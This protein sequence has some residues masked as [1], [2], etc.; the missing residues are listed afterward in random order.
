MISINSTIEEK[1]KTIA[2]RNKNF[3]KHNEN[4]KTFNQLEKELTVFNFLFSQLKN[5]IKDI[6]DIEKGY[7]NKGEII[8]NYISLLES[9]S[10]SINGNIENI[11][12]N[13]MD[14]QEDGY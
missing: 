9:L 11:Y 1:E 14:I 2:K 6:K 10:G 5:E 12:Y 3:Y 8:N 4:L 7:T 13:F